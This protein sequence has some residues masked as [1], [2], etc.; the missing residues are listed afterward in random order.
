ME[1]GGPDVPGGGAAHPLQAL[2]QLPGGLVGEGDGDDRPGDGGFHG[3]QPHGLLPVLRGG[4]LRELLQKGQVLL[5]GPAGDLLAVAAPAE[6]DKV[7]HPV[8]EDGGLAASGP[9]QEQEGTLGG[10]HGLPLAGIHAGVPPGDDG[11]AGG[12]VALLKI[13]YH[14]YVRSLFPEISQVL[15]YYPYAAGSTGNFQF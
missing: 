4:L 8:D 7:V 1:G 3:A 5:G 2:L 12:D 9:G 10:Q 15:F 11:P 13:L 6:G 14:K